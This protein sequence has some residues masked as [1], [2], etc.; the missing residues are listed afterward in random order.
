MTQSV[1][2]RGV[3]LH[4]GRSCRVEV[5]RRPGPLRLATPAA[6]A[7]LDELEVVATARATTV[8][9]RDGRLR[10]GTVEH[11]L[12]ALGGLGVREG[13]TLVVDGP[14]LPLLDGG[15]LAWCRA[16]GQ[17]G[18]PRAEDPSTGNARGEPTPLAT[19]APM[20]ITRT[21]SFQIGPS[22]F[23]FVPGDA[24]DLSVFADLGDP[25]F[26]P[27]ARW[28][29]DP[30]DFVARIAPART[31]TLSRDVEELL[32]RG[33]ARHVDPESVVVLAPDAV[34]SAGRP[35]TFDEPARHKLLDLLGDLV[36][37]GGPARGRI[38]AVHPGHAANAR[39]LRRARLEGIL[40]PIPV[41]AAS[42]ASP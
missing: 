24:I 32:R 2:L 21:A 22:R 40:A 18:L 38:H 39:A 14:E 15:A 12:S 10:L 13:V 35:F 1:E 41:T 30:A 25:R 3:G 20:R 36:L 9:T 34:H 37:H 27:A 7:T 19:P 4:T 26:P 8:S 5:Q 28:R 23:E 11:F 31:F 16:L 6:E 29:G 42:P 17:L 33:L